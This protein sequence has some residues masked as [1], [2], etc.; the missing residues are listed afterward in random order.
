MLKN[1]TLT[2]HKG[3]R[4]KKFLL[5]SLLLITISASGSIK[6]KIKQ[7]KHYLEQGTYEGFGDWPRYKA[8]PRSRYYTFKKAFEHFDQHNGKVVV[9]LGTT[10]SFTHGGHPG[11]CSSDTRH[12]MPN[13]PEF[14][15]WGAGSFTRVAAETLAHLH[16]EFH[17]IDLSARHIEISKKITEEFDFMHYH[18][19]S[20]LTFLKNCYFPNGIDLLYLDTG[21]ITPIEPTAQLHLAEAKI[22]VERNLL[23]P[24]GIILI[25]DVRNQAPKKLG[26]ASEYGKAK[27]SLPYLLSHGFELVEDEYQVILKKSN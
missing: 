24:N 19:C 11:C 6:D 2:F 13:K 27:Y 25:D 9:E 16:P 21:N 12:W 26:E 20:S 8:K 23:A 10:R 14:W 5:P 3:E 4:M 15:D 22:I 17:T 18:V 7:Y 1:Q